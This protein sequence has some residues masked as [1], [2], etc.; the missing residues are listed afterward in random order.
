MYASPTSNGNITFLYS[1]PYYISTMSSP[2]LSSSPSSLYTYISLRSISY[3]YILLN[4]FTTL[5][6][7]LT[8]PSFINLSAIEINIIDGAT[9][10]NIHV[11]FVYLFGNVILHNISLHAYRCY[12]INSPINTHIYI[13]PCRAKKKK[14]IDVNIK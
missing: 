13:L 8:L 9:E 12:I 2:C 14:N 4:I 1:G 11:M 7:A 10:Y 6:R 3:T 5:R